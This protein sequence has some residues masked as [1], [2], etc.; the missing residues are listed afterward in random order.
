VKNVSKYTTELRYI[1]ENEKLFPPSVGQLSL[2]NILKEYPLLSGDK[3]NPLN[4]K[5][6]RDELN[7]KIINHYYFREIGYETVP[8]FLFNLQKKLNEIMPLYN[9][10]YE[11][12][13]LEINPIDNVNM[14]E[15]FEHTISGNGTTTSTGT[16]RN[17]GTN[18]TSTDGTGTGEF[19]T[20][21]S[22]T[23]QTG[24]TETDIKANTYAS[25][26]NHGNNSST[27]SSDT[28]NTLN[29]TDTMDGE[30][31][32]TDSKT[33][34]FTRREFGSSKGYT[35]AQNIE[36]WRNIMIN[37]DMQIIDELN[38]LFMNIW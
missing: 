8:M 7:E 18:T 27:S 4:N 33:E 15:T 24:I 36:Q 12:I 17:T 37:V 32:V 5:I 38:D 29:L 13:D 31:N 11:S 23:P 9:Q 6:R 25:K 35:F 3:I 1:V 28:T 22:D 16:N 19:I 26:T 34:S 2:T 30:V 20:V 21:E 14:T 10:M